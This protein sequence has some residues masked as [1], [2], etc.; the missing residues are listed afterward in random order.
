MHLRVRSAHFQRGL[1]VQHKE[2]S[3]CFI[4][5][6]LIT[7]FIAGQQPFSVHRQELSLSVK[8]TNQRRQVSLLISYCLLDAFPRSIALSD[9]LAKTKTCL[10]NTLD[11]PRFI[12]N[13]YDSPCRDLAFCLAQFKLRSW[14]SY[15]AATCSRRDVVHLHLHEVRLPPEPSTAIMAAQPLCDQKTRS[16]LSAY[17]I[18]SFE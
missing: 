16:P 2:S 11:V 18:T 13:V 6:L 1:R 14:T 15:R 4:Y 7:V 3:N 17:H 8:E 9:T 10:R 12:A 5:E